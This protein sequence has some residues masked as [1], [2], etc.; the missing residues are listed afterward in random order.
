MQ[1]VLIDLIFDFQ[2]ENNGL[3]E[4]TNQINIKVYNL[5]S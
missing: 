1:P 5:F 3:S 2:K 4:N